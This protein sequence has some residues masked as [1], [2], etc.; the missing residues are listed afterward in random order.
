[1][2]NSIYLF[3]GEEKYLIETELNKIKKQFGEKVPGINY[4]LID[5]T[6]YFQILSDIQTPA[7]GY[8]KKLII[9]KNTGLFQKSGR[10]KKKGENQNSSNHYSSQLA[11]YI[12]E[13][14]TNLEETVILIFVE[15][16]VEKNELY[17]SIEKHGQILQ[18]QKL[19][20]IEAQKRIQT[21][22]QAYGVKID[23]ATSQ[24]LIETCGTEMQT[25]I[26]EIRKQ[27]EYVQKDGTITK[28]N[29]DQLAIKQL[30]MVIFDLTDQLGKKEIKKSL[31][32]LDELLYEREPIQKILISLYY[33]FKKLYFTKI[34]IEEKEDIAKALKLKPNQLFLVSKYRN[35][36]QYFSKEKLREIL[37]SMIN[38]DEDYKKRK[39]RSGDWCTNYYM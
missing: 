7:F 1:M 16:T 18:F 29:I 14:W 4:L 36:C 25:L 32:I 27:I 34:A 35:Q 5:E 22:C 33:H 10:G 38:L 21:I 17:E 37:Q 31:E 20:P 8:P 26:N 6:N 15:E 13:N 30:D 39:D 3:Y 2:A 9:A 19:K 28:E 11:R 12:E 23:S 24:Y